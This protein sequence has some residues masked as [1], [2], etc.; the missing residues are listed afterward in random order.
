[1]ALKLE[2]SSNVLPSGDQVNVNSR[3]NSQVRLH[4]NKINN[5]VE[6]FMRQTISRDLGN[7][8]SFG[9]TGGGEVS[10]RDSSNPGMV[11][12]KSPEVPI[13]SENYSG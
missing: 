3:E 11:R 12:I 7:A 2:K 9:K 5:E 8:S 10:K 6:D 4:E 1:M 13:G